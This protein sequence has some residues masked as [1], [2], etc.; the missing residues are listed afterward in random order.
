MSIWRRERD[1]GPTFSGSR[2][3]QEWQLLNEHCSAFAEP[4][5]RADQQLIRTGLLRSPDMV[6]FCFSD[7]AL[8]KVFP[9]QSRLLIQTP[10]FRLRTVP[11]SF[12]SPATEVFLEM[13]QQGLVVLARFGAV[14]NRAHP[15]LAR[16]SGCITPDLADEETDCLFPSTRQPR[17]DQTNL[18]LRLRAI[19]F[20]L[21]VG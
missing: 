4:C 10:L 1:C 20:G 19:A 17:T 13:R 9:A 15:L 7:G 2:P 5:G 12:R 21:R 6:N 3:A 14:E 8:Q 11:F 16:L 18:T